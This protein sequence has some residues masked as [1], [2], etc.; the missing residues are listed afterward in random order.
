MILG[1]SALSLSASC[2]ATYTDGS[3]I[4]NDTKNTVDT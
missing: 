4:L 1:F 2:G 3:Q